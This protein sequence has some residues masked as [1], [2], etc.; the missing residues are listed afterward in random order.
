MRIK[1]IEQWPNWYPDKNVLRNDILSSVLF[2]TEYKS[3]IIGMVVLSP[4]VPEVYKSI[5]WEYKSGKVNSIHRLAVHPV[6]KTPEMGKK[7]VEYVEGLAKKQGYDIIRLDTY[8]K[9]SAADK[10]YRKMGYQYAGD[11]HLKFMPEH[12]QCFEKAL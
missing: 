7:L 6:F 4:E 3:R 2:V 11:I 5:P 1:G 8:S 12:Y 10:F 9:N